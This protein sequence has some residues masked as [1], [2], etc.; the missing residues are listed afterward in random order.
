MT[1]SFP[2]ERTVLS[3]WQRGNFKKGGGEEELAF[4]DSGARK[5]LAGAVG[6]S[7][8]TPWKLSSID[9]QEETTSHWVEL[10]H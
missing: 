10:E 5:G 4:S 9:S 6:H 2:W 8:W 1:C 3:P 7:M